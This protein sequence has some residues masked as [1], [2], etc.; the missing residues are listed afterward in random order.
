MQHDPKVVALNMYVLRG[1]NN[2]I[3]NAQ[4]SNKDPKKD[5]YKLCDWA[6]VIEILEAMPD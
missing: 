6:K 5:V 3:K 1:K 4:D 2:A